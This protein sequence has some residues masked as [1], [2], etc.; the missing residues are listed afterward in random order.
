MLFKIVRRAEPSSVMRFGSPLIAIAVTV[1]IS[2]VVFAALGYN[3]LKALNAFFLTPISTVNGIS[4]LI[5]KASPLILI[6]C[7]LAIGFRANVWN[8]GG[9]GQ[10]VAGAIA[11]GGVALFYPNPNSRLLLPLMFLA[12]LFAGMG[13]AAIPAFLKTRL[14]TNEILTTLMLNYVALQL[15]SWLV[16]GP[17]RGS[18]ALGRPITNIFSQSAMWPVFNPA[19][20]VN[21]S[22]F[23]TA[24]GVFLMWLFTER[25]F[26]GYK[27][28]VSVWWRRRG[29]CRNVCRSGAARPVRDE[30]HGRLWFCGDRCR[31]YRS[32]EG[33]R[34]RVGRARRGPD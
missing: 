6:G 27:M 21:V 5:L 2:A 14:N 29:C 7:G 24:A 3:P 34:H 33:R 13:W 19:Y 30:H 16:H 25:S 22:V 15:L 12:A 26:A 20:R 11:A 1:V 18:A 32:V 10:W 31:F 28:S 23:V 4:E 17:W 9:Q 8:I